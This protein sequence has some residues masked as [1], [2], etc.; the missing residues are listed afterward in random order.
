MQN[1]YWRMIIIKRSFQLT[2]ITIRSLWVPQ[3]VLI[4]ISL[5]YFFFYF[6]YILFVR[7]S[8]WHI[9]SNGVGDDTSVVLMDAGDY[10]AFRVLLY[11]DTD[12]IVN[13]SLHS[14][15]PFYSYTTTCHFNWN[16]TAL[17][18]YFKH[19]VAWFLLDPMVFNK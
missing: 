6:F 3:N 13:G 1:E 11:F 17:F 14:Q 19:G 4:Y 15:T 5:F 9:I 10:G 7:F 2:Q 8:K 16:T 12:R 18:Y